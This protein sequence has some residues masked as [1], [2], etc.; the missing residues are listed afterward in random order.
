MIG[1]HND[2]RASLVERWLRKRHYNLAAVMGATQRKTRRTST[3]VAWRKPRSKRLGEKLLFVWL[4]TRN[5]RF[6]KRALLIHGRSSAHLGGCAPCVGRHNQWVE[7]AYF[8]SRELNVPLFQHSHSSM[9]AVQ[10]AVCCL[11]DYIS[12]CR[13]CCWYN[14]G[15]HSYS[16]QTTCPYMTESWACN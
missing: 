15:G 8:T 16:T 11:F 1:D 5:H 12:V 4:I 14:K 2:F 6:V 3:C 10:M 7:P 9:S 13:Q